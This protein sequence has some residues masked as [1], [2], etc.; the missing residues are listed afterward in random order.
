MNLLGL[1]EKVHPVQASNLP[2][3]KRGDH[4]SKNVEKVVQEIREIFESDPLAC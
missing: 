3:H 4:C 2:R 1:L